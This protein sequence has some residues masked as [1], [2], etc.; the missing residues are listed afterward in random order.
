MLIFL[1]TETT[2]TGPE[3][4]KGVKSALDSIESIC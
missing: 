1:D 2:G 4:S 3:D